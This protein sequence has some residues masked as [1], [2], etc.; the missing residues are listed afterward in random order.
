MAAKTKNLTVAY[1]PN[2]LGRNPDTG[3]YRVVKCRNS[4]DY[5]PGTYISKT[6]VD[7]VIRR[8]GWNVDITG[9]A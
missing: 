9:S 1:D 7:A 4:T 8:S 3:E 5:N 6:E 2:A